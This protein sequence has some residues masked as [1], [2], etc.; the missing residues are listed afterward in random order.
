MT[1][2]ITPNTDILFK[3]ATHI[4]TRFPNVLAPTLTVGKKISV[5]LVTGK[6]RETV[7]E[8]VRKVKDGIDVTFKV[9]TRRTRE[10]L[11]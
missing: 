3:R 5:R 8:A 2:E 7:I 10:V 4:T 6:L 1:L 9:G 11:R